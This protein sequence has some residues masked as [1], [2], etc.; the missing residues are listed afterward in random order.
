MVDGRLLD[1]ISFVFAKVKGNNLPFGNL[2][3]VVLGDLLQLPPVTGL[4]VWNAQVWKIFNPLFLRQPQRQKDLGFFN[5]FNKIRFGI[6][7][8]E[9]RAKLTARWKAYDPALELWT[10]TFL[11]SLREEA[12]V[13]NDTVLQ[14]M[15]R[16]NLTWISYAEDFENGVR[17]D[18]SEKSTIFKRGTNFAARV[19]C[20]VGAKVMFLTNSMLKDKGISNGSIGV[21]TEV[22]EEGL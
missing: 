20:K 10:T 18:I 14:G 11:S 4:K 13:L 8:D 12:K 21:I 22:T 7:D 5:L 19:V 2:H 17:I 15:P 16:E 6:V 3:V 1:F 9:V